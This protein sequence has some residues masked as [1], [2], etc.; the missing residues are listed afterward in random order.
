MTPEE[1][2]RLLAH[3]AAFDNRQ[4][5]PI[6]A[7]AWAAALDDI[8]LDQDAIDAI[9]TYYSADGTPGERR[10]LM[11]FHI[12]HYRA[13]ARKQRIDAANVVY[14]GDPDETGPEFTN[15]LRQLLRTAGDGQLGARTTRQALSDRR[16]LEL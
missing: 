7:K 10:W 14:D 5:S 16:P 1:A 15:N 3:A 12:R 6:A 13:I 11:P 9:T 4:P 2:G 8:P